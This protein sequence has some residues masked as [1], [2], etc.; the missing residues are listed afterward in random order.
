M[1]IK[2]NSEE[3]ESNIRVIAPSRQDGWYMF[4]EYDIPESV[5]KKH[6]VVI[7]KSEPETFSVLHNQII[8]KVR[9]IFGI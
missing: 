1:A 2:K 7:S 3:S 4:T 5:L 6:A 8:S 9:E